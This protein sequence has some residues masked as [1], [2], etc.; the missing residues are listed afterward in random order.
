MMPEL[1]PVISREDIEKS[2]AGVAE[3][4]SA[5]YQHR[6]PILVGVLK[7]AFVFLSDLI[8]QLTIPVR[9]DFIRTTSY[10]GSMSSS[11]TVRL[12]KQ[13]EIDIAEE[14]VLLVE[15]IVDSGITLKWLLDYLNGLGP[16]SVKTCALLDKRERRQVDVPVDYVCHVG[17]EGFLVGYGLDYAE[18]FR[19]LPAI[20]HLKK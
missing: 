19:H 18:D 3:K 17:Q 7:G 15:D 8:R 14:D 5:D 16:A 4:I 11:G 13:L 10:G 12:T 9:I 1:I 20:Y 2:I 6:K